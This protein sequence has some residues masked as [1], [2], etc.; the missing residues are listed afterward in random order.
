M[1]AVKAQLASNLKVHPKELVQSPLWWAEQKLDGQR[2]IVSVTNGQVKAFN[3][4]GVEMTIPECIAQDFSDG[5]F[6]KGQ[7]MFDGEL[8]NK[9]YYIFDL[10]RAVEDLTEFPLATRHLKLEQ[11][12]DLWCPEHCHLVPTA[13]TEQEKANLVVSVVEN[14]AEG[15]VFKQHA[16][17]YVG[18]KRVTSVVKMKF[19]DTADCVIMELYREGKP[20]A[21][22]IGAYD[23]TGTLTEVSGLK[24]PENSGLAVG[25]V[26]EVRYLYTSTSNKL[27]QP[28]FVRKRT[29]KTAEECLL[30]QL[31]YT[32]K[33]LV[34]F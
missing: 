26:V 25:D 28:V 13:K 4:G 6:A 34:G 17:C 14:R 24:V 29:D 8:I 20:Q 27:T 2:Y 18:G 5:T 32:S 30:T 12:F 22:T 33:K 19:V 21:V 7:W 3:R 1:V 15:I 16:S 11:V 31:R 10:L 23:A 9:A